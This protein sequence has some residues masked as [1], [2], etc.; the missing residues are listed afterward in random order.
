MTSESAVAAAFRVLPML[1]EDLI[2]H[3]LKSQLLCQELRP[4]RPQHARSY[5]N[6]RAL[7]VSLSHTALSFP[8]IA[9][10]LP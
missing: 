6:L 3:S 8:T 10:I 7:V 2:L 5:H 9:Q 4:P 1:G